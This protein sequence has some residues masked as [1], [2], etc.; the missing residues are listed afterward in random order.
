[1]KLPRLKFDLQ[2]LLLVFV[3]VATS[4]LTFKRY[5]EVVIMDEFLYHNTGDVTF[6]HWEHERNA[7]R[8]IVGK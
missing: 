3:L 6:K 7:I 5:W 2:V 1:M 4:V 8:S